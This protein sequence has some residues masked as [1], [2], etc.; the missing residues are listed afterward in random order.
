MVKDSFWCA[1]LTLWCGFISLFSQIVFVLS[2][3]KNT[4]NYYMCMDTYPKVFSGMPVKPNP[5]IVLV[6]LLCA[7]VNIFVYTRICIFKVQ[8]FLK[9]TQNQLIIFH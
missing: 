7:G 6:G 8:V 3:G 9:D 1:F 2:P 4:M 5:T